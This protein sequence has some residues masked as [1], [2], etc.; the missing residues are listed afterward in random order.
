MFSPGTAG[1]AAAAAAAARP[2]EQ[3]HRF[4]RRPLP[5]RRA[6][7]HLHAPRGF[8]RRASAARRGRARRFGAARRR[9]KTRVR[10]AA[11]APRAPPA[12]ARAAL[13]PARADGADADADAGPVRPTRRRVRR[14][15]VRSSV[16]PLA[17]R[18]PYFARGGHAPQALGRGHDHEV[19]I[20]RPA[21]H[22]AGRVGF[23]ASRFVA[24]EDLTVFE[25][26]H[27]R[28]LLGPADRAGSAAARV[29]RPA[30]RSRRGVGVFFPSAVR[31]GSQSAAAV[32][33]VRHPLRVCARLLPPGVVVAVV[34]DVGVDLRE[35][36]VRVH[37]GVAVQPAGRAVRVVQPASLAV[38]SAAGP[39]GLGARSGALAAPAALPG[40]PLRPAPRRLGLGGSALGANANAPPPSALPPPP[41]PPP[42]TPAPVRSGLRRATRRR[43]RRSCLRR[44][45]TPSPSP[46]LPRMPCSPSATRRRSRGRRFPYRARTRRRRIR[47]TH[48]PAR[49]PRR[50]PAPRAFACSPPGLSPR[51]R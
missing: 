32:A 44:G 13:R 18:A 45:T 42:T 24:T 47:K 28:A 43:R 3:V 33:V 49:L 39:A 5:G 15:V 34:V 31:V 38:R 26:A 36:A 1:A 16:R 25:P 10:G 37:G 23:R 6:L 27:G 9:R 41:P 29:V 4:R 22:A 17:L 46:S 2:G 35:L 8:D 11:A 48:P 7:Q 20:H 12:K 30:P 51:S 21:A 50:T 14:V 40:P 19:V